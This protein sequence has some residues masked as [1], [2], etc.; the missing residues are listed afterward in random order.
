MWT[1]PIRDGSERVHTTQKP[2]WLMEALVRDFTDP[3]EVVLDPFAGSGTTGV[4]AKRLGRGFIGW[5][6]DPKYAAIAERRIRD[7]REQ[8]D[9]TATMTP[10][11]KQEPLL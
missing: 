9:I 3:G 7:A 8:L 5:E 4:A 1:G 6:R 2:L 11:A 10:R